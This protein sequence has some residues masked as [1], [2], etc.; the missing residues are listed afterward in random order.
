MKPKRTLLDD[1]EK[2][3]FSIPCS[4]YRLCKQCKNYKLCKT[5]SYTIKSL[6][7]HYLCDKN[8]ELCKRCNKIEE[9][10]IIQKIY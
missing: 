7:K 1:L 4:T 9:C 8:Y 2:I 3:Y 6:K 10:E 5:L